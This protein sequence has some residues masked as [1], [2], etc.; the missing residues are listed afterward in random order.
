MRRLL[1]ACLLTGLAGC[2]TVPDLGPAPQPASVPA[3]RTLAG[4]PDAWPAERW[5]TDFGDPQLDRLVEEA[6]AASPSLAQ[7]AARLRV[8]AAQTDLAR[9]ARAPRVGFTA[10]TRESRLTQSIGL[11]TDGEW[12]LLAAGLA[13]ASHDLD[14]WGRT[15]AAIRAA[16]STAQAT[17]ADHAAARHAVVGAVAS[18]YVRFAHEHLRQEVAVSAERIRGA[19]RDLVVRRYD[20]GLE[21]RAAVE[22]AEGALDTARADLAAAR[23]AMDLTRHMLAALVGDGPDRGLALTEPVLRQRRPAGLPDDVPLALI[24]RRPEILAARW[25]VDAA[26]A[27]IGVAHADFRPHVSLNGLIGLASFGLGHLFD[28]RSVIGS[29]GP[30]VS[31]PILDGGRRSAEYRRARGEYEAAVAA[32]DAVLLKALR[33]AADAAASLR[34]LG[35]RV[36]ATDAALTRHEAAYRLSRIRY[37]G[38]LSDYHAVLTSEN[39]VI[40]AREQAASLRLRGVLLDIALA[41]SLGGGFRASA[42]LGIPDADA[43][44]GR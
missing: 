3:P 26:G 16:V 44:T 20:A 29:A 33:Q 34:A 5:W 38:G 21:A 4:G 18:T 10:T 6:L 2:A 17:A 37:E 24:G 36:A 8:A 19:M 30:A 7:A 11:P 28:A 41:Q 22:Q 14:L 40:A 1:I 15:R 9:A 27:R 25:R 12:H 39:G 35:P 23:E 43:R 32:Y 42:A 31:L 13:S